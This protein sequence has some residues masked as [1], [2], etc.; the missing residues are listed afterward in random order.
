MIHFNL[1]ILQIT[2]VCLCSTHLSIA[3]T[4]R[5]WVC[6]AS[7]DNLHN[8]YLNNASVN[9][10]SGQ[11]LPC[12]PFVRRLE[13]WSLREETFSHLTRCLPVVKDLE[14][15]IGN[16]DNVDQAM[17]RINRSLS[18]IGHTLRWVEINGLLNINGSTVSKATCEEFART[19]QQ[20]STQLETLCMVE[21]KTEDEGL[22][23]IVQSCKGVGTLKELRIKCDEHLN[24]DT[25]YTFLDD[26]GTRMESFDGF[27]NKRCKCMRVIVKH[28]DNSI[29]NW[30]VRR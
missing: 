3:M 16:D 18:Q 15:W 8:L 23:E 22:V 28:P 26:I 10:A 14:V 5:L 20:N 21:I 12:L 30:K 25:L 19:V 2:S 17:E 4:T 27:R 29:L 9:L 1:L 7:F 11:S 24:K 6:L 13:A